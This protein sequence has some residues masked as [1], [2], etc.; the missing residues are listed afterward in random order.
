MDCYGNLQLTF[1]SSTAAPL[2][3]GALM[4]ISTMPAG[5]EHAFQVIGH[6]STGQQTHPYD[7]HEILAFY[8][9]IDAG[10]GLPV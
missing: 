10:Y 9:R 7:I 4:R 3:F 5:F 6:D 2:R 1:F 8:Q